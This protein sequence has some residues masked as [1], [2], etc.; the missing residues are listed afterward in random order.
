MWARLLAGT[1]RRGARQTCAHAHL[2]QQAVRHAEGTRRNLPFST[3]HVV[4][5]LAIL[6]AATS[7][8]RA[9]GHI[10]VQDTAVWAGLCTGSFCRCHATP[11][12]W[13]C[14]VRYKLQSALQASDA[15]TSPA[16]HLLVT[17]TH[18][19]RADCDASG[20]HL[21]PFQLLSPERKKKVSFTY[22]K[23]LRELS[24]PDKVFDYFASVQDSDG[25]R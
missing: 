15:P 3:R 14:C 13:L 17:G 18:M 21:Q 19:L 24:P 6:G 12:T 1:V 20:P 25:A 2:H 23:R 7:N 10:P 5:A 8:A 16:P 9:E 22:E 11:C 4:A